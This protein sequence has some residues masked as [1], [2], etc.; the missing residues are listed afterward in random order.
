MEGYVRASTYRSDICQCARRA[1]S[2]TLPYNGAL[3]P[4]DIVETHLSVPAN[5]A[6]RARGM[7]Y[8]DAR[9]AVFSEGGG[10]WVVWL[11]RG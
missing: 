8:Y 9:A 2:S 7:S 4:Q 11:Y 1:P 3:P 6:A 10:C 5:E